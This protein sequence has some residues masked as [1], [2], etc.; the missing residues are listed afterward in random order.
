MS[1]VILIGA[2]ALPR[3][4]LIL[5]LSAIDT[6][7]NKQEIEFQLPPGMKVFEIV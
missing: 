7:G 1:G 6:G 4:D 2:Q 5:T 3:A